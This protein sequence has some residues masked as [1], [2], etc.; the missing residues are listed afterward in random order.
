M[1]RLTAILMSFCMILTVLPMAAYAKANTSEAELDHFSKE[2]VDI[3][4]DEENSSSLE[5]AVAKRVIVKASTSIPTFDAVETASGFK[6]YYVLEFP[7]EAS[8]QTAVDYYNS[9]AY[10][11]FAQLDNVVTSSEVPDPPENHLSYNSQTA[12][13]TE[14]EKYMQDNSITYSEKLTV[15]VIDTGVEHTHEFLQGRVEPTEYN[16]SDSGDEHSALDDDGHGTHVAGIIADNTPDNVII[17]PYKVLNNEGEGTTLGAVLGVEQAIADGVDIINMSLGARGYDKAFHEAVKAAYAKNIPVVVSS[18]NDRVNMDNLP[19]SP[20]A[21]EECITVKSSSANYEYSGNSGYSNY[22]SMCD[23][24]A[25]GDSIKSSYLNNTYKFLSGTS[26]AAPLVTAAAVYL[27]LEYKAITAPQVEQRL[28][29]YSVPLFQQLRIEPDYDLNKGGLYVEFITREIST[30]NAPIFSREGGDFDE[31]FTLELFTEN[32]GEIYYYTGTGNNV[33]N[34][35]KYEKPFEIKYGVTIS[36]FCYRKGLKMSPVVTNTYTR[37]STGADSD[38]DI[39]ANGKIIEYF[40][41]EENVFIPQELKGITV[42]EIGKSVFNNKSLKSVTLPD[43]VTKIGGSA[44]YCCKSLEAVYANN[45]TELEGSAFNGC[46]SLVYLDISKVKNIPSGAFSGCK[47]LNTIDFSKI[48]KIGGS[49]FSG[50]QNIYSCV[51]DTIQYL[52]GYAFSKT[53]IELVDLPQVD[54][55]GQYTFSNCEKLEKVYMPKIESISNNVFDHCINLKEVDLN[56]A[57]RVSR[58]AFYGCASLESLYFPNLISILNSESSHFAGC[59]LLKEFIAPKLES[60]SDNCFANCPNL[61]KL[62]FPE[63]KTINRYTFSSDT[64]VEYLYAPK[65][66]TAY[67]LPTADYAV[68]VT[69]SALTVCNIMKP[70]V[71][72]PNPTLI[73]QGERGSFAEEYADKYSLEF[74]DVDAMGGSIRVT[75]AGLRFGYSFYDTQDKDVEEFGFVYAMGS[76]DKEQLTPEKVDGKTVYKLVANNRITHDDGLTTF[77]LVFTGMPKTAY[78]QNVSARAYV[79]I[80]GKYLYSDILD[81]SFIQVANAVLNDD[82][83]DSATKDRVSQLLQ[84]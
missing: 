23:I 9:L 36:A 74:V 10:V 16:F 17:R 34:I 59:T 33:S 6:N 63:L 32:G 15:A 29:D 37:I 43:T 51:S 8:A 44:F 67:S 82:G 62:I 40:N 83:I 41:D 42:R 55:M 11:S 65:L 26:M 77:N 49:A 69:T 79:K 57:V 22:G 72:A 4:N 35:W 13:F 14:L 28:K 78:S 53:N 21:F 19:Y 58:C 76:V 39:D 27:L 3:I 47:S 50:C 2:V 60:V 46:S 24:T 66:T 84:A 71:T 68:I 75:D 25:P 54:F 52:D 20:A 45:I 64:F 73:I 80:N 31:S 5:Q 56:R 12:G 7:S 18:G 61:K 1:K 30:Q 38:F 48:E 81:R 70:M